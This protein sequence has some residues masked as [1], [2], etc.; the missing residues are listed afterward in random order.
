MSKLWHNTDVANTDT[1]KQLLVRNPTKVDPKQSRNPEAT[2]PKR[3]KSAGFSVRLLK[4]PKS[5]DYLLVVTLT[6]EEWKATAQLVIRAH[7]AAGERRRS[8]LFPI[9]KSELTTGFSR[10]IPVE[11]TTSNY[12]H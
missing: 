6:T 3:K 7:S 11:R 9:G 5:K 4:Q 8:L 12:Q 10:H 2:C 1:G